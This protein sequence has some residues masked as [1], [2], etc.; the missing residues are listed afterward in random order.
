M[1]R[2]RLIMPIIM[3]D[4]VRSLMPDE[5]NLN[6]AAAALGPEALPHL[7]VLVRGPDPM[8]ASKATYVAGL[9]RDPRTVQVLQ[10]AAASTDRM[11][12]LTAAA[13]AQHLPPDQAGVILARLLSD[14][15]PEV[16]R[17]AIESIPSQATP[18][19]LKVLETLALTDPYAFIRDLAA[20]L[21]A[22]HRP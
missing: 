12:R 15:D 1:E 6:Q 21:V 11:V 22:K 20:Q 3:Q 18:D 13:T 10:I 2:R 4:V 7:E 5:A 9:L 17:I 16:R 19:V 14:S 8:L